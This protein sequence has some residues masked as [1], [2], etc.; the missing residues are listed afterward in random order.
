MGV[1]GTRIARGSA[2]LSA[3][4]FIS[5]MIAFAGSIAIARLLKPD[6]Y[7]LIGIALI[8]PG[9]LLGLLDLG[10][11]E[12]IIR[13]SPLDKRRGYISTVFVFKVAMAV[14]TSLLV[15]I[16][17]DYMADALNRPYITPMI[18]I[19]SIY[20]LGEIV[21]G[22]IGQVLI[23][24]GEYDKAGFLSIVR[25]FVRVASSI[26]L[27]V[28]GLGVY[29]S[30]WGFSIASASVLAVS[31]IY[32]SKYIDSIKFEIELFKEIIKFSLPLYIP[33]LLGLPLNQIV[34]IF[35]ARYATNI[36][37]GNYSV[38]SN[39]L[40]PLGIVG[41]S[42]ATSIYST[43][44]LLVDRGD[45]LREVVYKSVT[46][47]SII[48]LPMAMGLIVFSKPLVYL[49]YSAQYSL[50]PVY[51]S[52]SA[53]TGLTVVLGS[54]VIGP[55]LKSIGETV[56]IMKIS[57]VNCFIYI[58]LAL[59][60]IPTYRV[61]GLIVSGV[62][63]G[64]FSTLYGLYVVSRDFRLE[65]VGR[66]NVVILGALSFPA[67]VAWITS[68]LPLSSFMIKFLLEVVIYLVFLALVLPF[69]LK[70]SEIF[71]FIELLK[72]VKLFSFIAPRIL[73]IILV[74]SSLLNNI[75]SR[76][77]TNKHD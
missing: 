54:Y 14:T 61:V 31:L 62:I 2:W 20:A 66:R 27:I 45:K 26:L 21:N 3:G 40:V 56:K 72:S 17:S 47:T 18:K 43:L 60:L 59:L 63:A 75:K 23:G 29:G 34:N 36:E 77:L 35:L 19:L 41:D 64:F 11:S 15:F 74:I 6:E 46:Y 44:P 51:L 28:I 50:A 4:Q 76:F 65:I 71:E 73:S 38:A 8:L 68:F 58:P 12:A 67:I 25:S 13:F 53:F 24:V 49:I 22:A 5:T 52:L 9:L 10:V 48:I 70:K 30:I 16:L 39:L 42:M 69:I 7:G 55:Y 1:A 33:T 57:F 32:V 37:L